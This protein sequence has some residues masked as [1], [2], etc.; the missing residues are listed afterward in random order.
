M[1]DLALRYLLINIK[2][3]KRTTKKIKR[4]FL[5]LLSLIFAIQLG[6]VQNPPTA[7]ALTPKFIRQF[8]ITDK[9]SGIT[10]LGRDVD[11]KVIQ[12]VFEGTKKEVKN[13]LSGG[14]DT[15]K[16]EVQNKVT[17]AYNKL[18]N[19]SR[20]AINNLN[21]IKE[22]YR[23]IEEFVNNPVYGVLKIYQ[24]IARVTDKYVLNGFISRNFG[25]VTNKDEVRRSL[26]LDFGQNCCCSQLRGSYVIFNAPN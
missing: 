20:K 16:P 6:I 12:P 13:C 5:F 10:K 23:S 2:M 3:K 19:S 15:T 4:I 22:T 1:H 25:H 18:E 14:C 7:N 8:D 11:S 21:Q 24:E 17:S 9:N 26:K